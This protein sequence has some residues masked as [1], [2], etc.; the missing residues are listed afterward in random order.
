MED[1][2]I[3]KAPEASQPDEALKEALPDEAL[4]TTAG[5]CR[6]MPKYP[7]KGLA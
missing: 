5:G 6:P 2:N 4:E 1:K 3:G 7:P